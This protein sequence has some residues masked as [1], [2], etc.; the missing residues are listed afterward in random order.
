MKEINRFKMELLS[1]SVNESFAR[2]AICSFASFLDPTVFEIGDI[3]T[4][5]S[6]VVT[7]CIVHGYKDQPGKIYIDV[8]IF[9][10]KRLVIRIRDRGCGIGDVT[11]AM[12]PLFTTGDTDERAGL[13]FTLME[14]CMDKV[15]V[16]S[17]PGRGTIVT[18]QKKLGATNGG[19]E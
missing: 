13:G 7:N 12:E 15:R 4:A 18:M 3:K 5:V 11:K 2:V 19:D 1:K 6:E 14:S 8:K 10:D 16:R 17:V 9:E